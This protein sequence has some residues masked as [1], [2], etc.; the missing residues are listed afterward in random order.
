MN[1]K[2]IWVLAAVVFVLLLY[3]YWVLMPGEFIHALITYAVLFAFFFGYALPLFASD[4]ARHD[5]GS[6]KEKRHFTAQE[7]KKR[8][9]CT[10]PN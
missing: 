3:G 5:A 2:L 9:H 7:E 10:S 4:D 8:Q 6:Q 1:E